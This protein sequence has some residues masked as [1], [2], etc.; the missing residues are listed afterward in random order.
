MSLPSALSKALGK[1]LIFFKCLCLKKI[2]T[3]FAECL[4]RGTRHAECHAP[5]LGKVFLFFF[6]F[7]LQFFC[8]A[9]L[10]HQEL[11]VTIWGF[12]VAFCYI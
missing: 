7:G 2:K 9:F 10:K 3:L 8:A 5:A 12:F 11:L 6:V 1:D 4:I